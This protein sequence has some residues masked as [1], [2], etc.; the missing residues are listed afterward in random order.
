[1]ASRHPK[2]STYAG[3]EKSFKSTNSQIPDHNKERKHKSKDKDK[4]DD[5]KRV[6]ERSDSSGTGLQ[7]TMD[8]PES[9]RSSGSSRTPSGKKHMLK[10]FI[11]E[12]REL[13]RQID[14]DAKPT[15]RSR[16]GTEGELSGYLEPSGE[17]HSL[18]GSD[19]DGGTSRQQTLKEET[20]EVI[21][22]APNGNLTMEKTYSKQETYTKHSSRDPSYSPQRK[23]RLLPDIPER[24]TRSSSGGMTDRE[25][26]MDVSPVAV[27]AEVQVLGSTCPGTRGNTL[28]VE[29]LEVFAPIYPAPVTAEEPLIQSSLFQPIAMAKSKPSKSRIPK[30]SRAINKKPGIK[31]QQQVIDMLKM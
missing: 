15:R 31:E 19:S 12:V 30:K 8:S 10:Y 13:R 2:M 25:Q 14:P 22:K 18:F 21:R 4:K 7:A 5:S 28:P 24:G 9:S 23:K 3:T 11:H 26:S 17:G 27:K 6:H 29:P 1:M 20:K 16:A